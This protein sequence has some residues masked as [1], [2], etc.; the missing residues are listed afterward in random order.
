[1][2]IVLN[3]IIEE[4]GDMSTEE[5]VNQVKSSLP[6]TGTPFGDEIEFERYDIVAETAKRYDISLEEAATRLVENNK[7][8]MESLDR[9]KEKAKTYSRPIEP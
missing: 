1:M 4:Y 3:D 8:L 7:E 9:A 6:F 5:I 2:S